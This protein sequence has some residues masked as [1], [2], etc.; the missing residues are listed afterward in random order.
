MGTN[1]KELTLSV[2]ADTYIAG[3]HVAGVGQRL[4]FV[5]PK[6]LQKLGVV[7]VCLATLIGE[8]P[9]CPHGGNGLFRHFVGLCQGRLN[10]FSQF[11]G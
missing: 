10:F 11:L 2:T 7:G 6:H 1:R 5:Q 9:H 4:L 3:P 8:A